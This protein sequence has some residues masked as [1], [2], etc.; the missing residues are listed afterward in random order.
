MNS[1]VK[2]E[3]KVTAYAVVRDTSELDN[4]SIIARAEEA[5]SG[6]PEKDFHWTKDSVEITST[7]KEFKHDCNIG[8]CTFNQLLSK[9]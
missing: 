3:Y 7:D 6:V 2:I 9:K 4:D 5:L 8:E 1:V